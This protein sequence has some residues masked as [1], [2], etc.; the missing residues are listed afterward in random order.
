ME[1]VGLKST[2]VRSNT[3]EQLVMSNGDLLS[4]RL[5]NFG[6]MKERRGN[7]SLG[8]IYDT[9][10]DKLEAIPGM[11]KEIIDEEELARFDRAHFASFGDFALNF[12]IVYWIETPAYKDFMDTT[13]SINLK[14]VRRFEQ[15]GIE[16][17]FPTQTIY[18]NKEEVRA[19]AGS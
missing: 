14:I 19:S 7:M 2:R 10:A 17:A 16:M 5:R 13:Q 12:A 4:S 18:V 9:P 3:G 1:N 15:E 11:I 8:V 6:R